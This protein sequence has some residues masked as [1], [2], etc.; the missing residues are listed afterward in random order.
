MPAR[1]ARDDLDVRKL[2]EFILRNIDGVEEGFA[3]VER[4]ASNE[5]VADSAGLLENF[6]LHEMLEAAF[7]R[8]NRIPRNVLRRPLDSF[9]VCIHH[10][11]SR[12]RD[13]G[14][15]SI[16]KEK[17]LARVVEEC[18]DVACDEVFVDRRGRQPT[19]D[20]ALRRRFCSGRASKSLT[21]RIHPSAA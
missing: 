3:G 4:N 20:R 21:A 14:D 12:W 16:R 15:I 10:A 6:L 8:E 2:A 7:F 5:S 11:H 18:G 13:H 9:A 17:N 1:S 19:A